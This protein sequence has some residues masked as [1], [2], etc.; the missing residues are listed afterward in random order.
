MQKT[1]AKGST[2]L[3]VSVGGSAMLVGMSAMDD[4]GVEPVI[5][6]GSGVTRVLTVNESQAAGPTTAP[7]STSSDGYYASADAATYGSAV[8]EWHPAVSSSEQANV[9]ANACAIQPIVLLG[10]CP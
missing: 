7:T 9:V 2:S 1:T 4:G 5:T 8:A 3:Y 6:I 10:P